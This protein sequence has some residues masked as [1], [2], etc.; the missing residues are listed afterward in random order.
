MAIGEPFGALVTVYGLD[1]GNPLHVQNSDNSNYVIIPFKL[2]GT[3]ND[4]IWS[5]DVKLALQA[6]KNIALLMTVTL[7][8]IIDSSANQHLTVSTIKNFNVVD[9]TSLNIIVGHSN[10]TLATISHVGNLKLSN[11]MILYD[12]LVVP[13]YCVSLLSVN[14]LTRDSKMYVGFDEDK[15]YIQ[16]LKRDT[17]LGW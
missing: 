15:F 14:K 11:T 7:G 6:R 2:L 10:R 3:E 5:G 16:D 4:R 9:I 1:A 12:V 13:G 8:W 17:V